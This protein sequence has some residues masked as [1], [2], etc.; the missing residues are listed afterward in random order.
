MKRFLY[1]SAVVLAFAACGGDKEVLHMQN[2]DTAEL[3]VTPTEIRISGK[4]LWLKLNVANATNGTLMIQRDQI[5]AHL[6]NGQTLTRA[7][8][9]G[10]YGWG[11]AYVNTH[12]P[13]I[14][15]PGA[16]HPLNVEYEEQGFKWKDIPSVQI[17]FA[18]AATINGQPVAVPA[19][20]VQR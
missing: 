2:V 8:A 7:I 4:K 15:P 18:G 16:M 13:Y 10:G 19:F 11:Y 5:V 20:V 9:K 14:I 6:P 17:D 3:H 1:A 12:Q